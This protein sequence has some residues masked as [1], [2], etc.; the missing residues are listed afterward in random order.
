MSW[1]CVR[2]CSTLN[3]TRWNLKYGRALIL[4][5]CK[6]HSRSNTLKCN[7]WWSLDSASLKTTFL[8]QLF[9]TACKMKSLPL[10]PSMFHSRSSFLERDVKRRLDTSS[11]KAKFSNWNGKS[12]HCD[13]QCSTLGPTLE[14]S[15]F[16][17]N[18][19]LEPYVTYNSV[20]SLSLCSEK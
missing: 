6:L 15:I 7:V 20:L 19:T 1:H 2:Q 8:D 16:N 9:G 13:P 14:G 11:L 3:L 5:T 18:P 12:W 4:Q 17:E 10:Y